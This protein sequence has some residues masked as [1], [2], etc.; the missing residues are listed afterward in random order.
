MAMSPADRAFGQSPIASCPAR[1]HPPE[2]RSMATTPA[3]TPAGN[4]PHAATTSARSG[5]TAVDFALVPSGV[6]VNPRENQVRSVPVPA[7][8]GGRHLG[9]EGRRQG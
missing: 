8:V 4:R 7:T 3:R 6:P 9:R 2:A 5:G 1:L